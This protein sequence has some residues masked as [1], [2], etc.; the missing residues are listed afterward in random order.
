M[1]ASVFHKI[2]CHFNR[3]ISIVVAVDPSVKSTG[4]DAGIIVAGRRGNEGYIL[5]DNTIQGSPLVW[6]KAAE[7]AY[8]EYKA[9]RI[10]AECNNGGEI[11]EAVIRQPIRTSPLSL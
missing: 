9:D 1:P 7:A 8:H 2:L 5:A 6:A 3:F 11:V 10:I 4:D